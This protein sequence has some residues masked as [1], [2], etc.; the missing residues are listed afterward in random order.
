MKILLRCVLRKVSFSSSPCVIEGSSLV[1]LGSMAALQEGDVVHFPSTP[2][3]TGPAKGEK[4]PDVSRLQVNSSHKA[5]RSAG[6]G[7]GASR[8]GTR[9]RSRKFNPFRRAVPRASVPLP[10]GNPADQVRPQQGRRPA[11]AVWDVTGLQRASH[12]PSGQRRVLG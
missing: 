3:L 12:R 4:A 10:R 11:A 5:E 8:T 2:H 7:T 6:G 9:E 1:T